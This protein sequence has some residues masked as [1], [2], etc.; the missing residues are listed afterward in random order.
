[1]GESSQRRSQHQQQRQRGQ[2]YEGH[3]SFYVG[4]EQG[5]QRAATARVCYGCGAGNHL[6]RACPLRDAPYARFQ[7]QGGPQQQ[8][9]LPFQSPQFHLPYYQMSQLPPTVQGAWTTTM[10]SQ[11]RSSQGSSARGR[12]SDYY[13]KVLFCRPNYNGFKHL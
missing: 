6:L 8:P 7:L 12:G 3:S 2:Q 13:Q 11:T 10:S 4:G 1:M 5:A 9:T